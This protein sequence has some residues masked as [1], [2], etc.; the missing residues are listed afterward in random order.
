MTETYIILTMFLLLITPGPS[1]TLLMTGA[2]RSGPMR[3]IK[4]VPYEVTAYLI[5][6]G[7][8][9]GIGVSMGEYKPYMQLVA[10]AWVVGLAYL[11]WSSVQNISSMR[12]VSP[13]WVFFTTLL[14]PKA[15][16]FGIALLPAM[17]QPRGF[18][19][20]AGLIAITGASWVLL[21]SIMQPISRLLTRVSAIWMICIAI[22]L[23]GTAVNQLI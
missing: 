2:G 6:T 3:A 14:N 11:M 18:V 8:I 1:N 4:L 13:G 15:F 16:V 9:Y 7:I 19:V 23:V 12:V 5:V 20:M 22:M 17:E 21:G 10:A